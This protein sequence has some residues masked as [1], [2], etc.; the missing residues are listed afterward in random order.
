MGRGSASQDG[1]VVPDSAPALTLSCS[2][3]G[4]WGPP[5][6]GRLPGGY[7]VVGHTG[8]HACNNGVDNAEE[9]GGQQSWGAGTWP[10]PGHLGLKCTGAPCRAG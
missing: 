5:R 6:A 10:P 8:G 9:D 2:E 1:P 3:H 7:R 4:L